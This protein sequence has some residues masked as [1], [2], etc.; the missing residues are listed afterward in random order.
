MLVVSGP[1]TVEKL[2][3]ASILLECYDVVAGSDVGDTVTHGLDDTCSFM[4]KDHGECALRILAGE[5]IGVLHRVSMKCFLSDG[6]NP[7]NSPVWQTPV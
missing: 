6:S 1:E 5:R 2:G 3:V 4:T 7:S